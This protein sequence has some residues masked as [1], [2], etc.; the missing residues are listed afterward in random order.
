[1]PAMRAAPKLTAA[2]LR[3]VANYDPLTG[4]FTWRIKFCKK[5]V[6]GEAAGAPTT[7][8]YI[9]MS[10]DGEKYLGHRL[11]WLYTYGT[12]PTEEVDHRDLNGMNNRIANLR[13]ASGAQNRQNKPKARRNTSGYKGVTAFRDKW[14]AQIGVHKR[15]VY[16]GIFS[17][18]EE[19]H[20]A[21]CAAAIKYHGEFA[22]TH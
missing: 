21:Y 20:A 19:A 15:N 13:E 1:M 8:G 3:E 9:Q 17:H 11:A 2:R 22:R 12:W 14:I 16:L 6:V 5:V 18:P 4:V 10:I 7:N